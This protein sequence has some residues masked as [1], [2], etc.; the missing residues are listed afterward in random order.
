M[1]PLRHVYISV[2]YHIAH[3]HI[4]NKAINFSQLATVFMDIYIVIMLSWASKDNSLSS[5]NWTLHNNNRVF[6]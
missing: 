5:D 4:Y 1:I 3:V 6:L 2:A